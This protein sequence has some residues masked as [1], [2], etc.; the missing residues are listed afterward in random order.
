M[1][2]KQRIENFFH[3]VDKREIRLLVGDCGVF[4]ESMDDTHNAGKPMNGYKKIQCISDIQEFIHGV[5]AIHEI[6][7]TEYKF[8]VFDRDELL[9]IKQ[10]ESYIFAPR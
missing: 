7:K 3:R 10:N 2:D 9:E 1:Q 4:I 5:W 8:F 6:T